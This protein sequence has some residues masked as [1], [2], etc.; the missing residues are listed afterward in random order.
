[1]EFFSIIKAIS[2]IIVCAMAIIFLKRSTIFAAIS[3]LSWA[4]LYT[5]F[6]GGLSV[7]SGDIILSIIL[8]SS[9]LT[10]SAFMVIVPGLYLNAILKGQG[11]LTDL[12]NWISEFKIGKEKLALLLLIGILPALE[13]LTGFGVSLFLG[14]PIFLKLFEEEQA[15]KL[16]ML[17]MM[18]L[19]WGTLG[20]ATIVGA[21]LSGYSIKEL[22]NVTSETSFFIFPVI[23]LISLKIMN[24]LD[25]WFIGI[26]LGFLFSVMLHI[27]NYYGYVEVSAILAGLLTTLIGFVVLTNRKIVCNSDG[28]RFFIKLKL[29][30][31]Y[32]LILLIIFLT[33]SINSIHIFLD[34]LFVIKNGAVSFSVF[35]SPGI[36]LF[37]VSIICYFIRPVEVEHKLLWKRSR[38]ACLSL[39][40]FILLAQTMNQI[41]MVGTLAKAV[42]NIG[43]ILPAILLAPLLGIMSG[44]IT[45]STLGGNAL[46]MT[47][48]QHIGESFHHGLLFSALQ[49]SSAGHAAFSSLPIIVLIMTIAKDASFNNV[50]N[51][52]ENHLLKF[53]LSVILVNYLILVLSLTFL[54]YLK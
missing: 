41:G 32:L 33:R 10:L 52:K 54:Y 40:F 37:I 26:S 16:S 20:L 38:I 45:G 28:F 39:F 6:T 15:C 35:S 29:I 46:V 1:M 7:N 13:S 17:G 34:K 51:I 53:G 19:P 8:S 43:G 4:I 23:S 3:G 49:N 44:F 42:Q 14:I 36:V 25:L 47:V 31:P 5:I 27:F 9:I 2:P 48:Q 18:V 24:K 50:I 21:G 11:K 22:G 12:V 30:F